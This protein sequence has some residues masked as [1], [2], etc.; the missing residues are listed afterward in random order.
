MQGKMSRA[1]VFA[2]LTP[3]AWVCLFQKEE[4]SP[5]VRY[6]YRGVHLHLQADSL[7]SANV[8]YVVQ[9]SE[10]GS[11]WTTRLSGPAAIVPGG[12]VDVSVMGLG[13]H[14]RV[15]LYSTGTGRVD[16]TV[17]L[18]E[19]QA[20]VSLWPDVGSIACAAYAEVTQY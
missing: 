13:K 9:D 11:T 5:S 6:N 3:N 12:A 19:D 16:A 7:N 14:Q 17:S 1:S 10:D 15:L 2:G 20:S 18:P 4:G 8:E